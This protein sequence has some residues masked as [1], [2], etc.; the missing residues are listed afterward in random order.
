MPHSM[1]EKCATTEVDGRIRLRRR[2][3]DEVEEAEDTG[4]DQ[5]RPGG[6]GRGGSGTVTGAGVGGG[7]RS[8]GGSGG[9]GVWTGGCS[10]D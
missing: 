8:G 6:R 9:D 7:G 2:A 3:V 10:S 4:G 5:S 1:A